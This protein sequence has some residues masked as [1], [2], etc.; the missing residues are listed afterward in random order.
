MNHDSI[1]RRSAALLALTT[2]L[3]VA[4]V[5]CGGPPMTATDGGVR[6]TGADT[7][8]PVM[9]T[10]RPVA[11]ETSAPM[12][13]VAG[14]PLAVDCLLQDQDGESF[15]APAGFMPQRAF[16]P[17]STVMNRDG[18]NIPTRA[19]D[20]EVACSAPSLRLV[21]ATPARVTVLPG[22]AARVVAR[23]EQTSVT[24]GAMVAVTCEAYDQFN[25]PVPM[26]GGEVNVAPTNSGNTVE[27]RTVTFT[28][29]GVYDV[30]C[31]LPGATAEPVRLEVLPGEPADLQISRVPDQPVYARDQLIEVRTRVT[32]R[33]GNEIPDAEVSVTS[34]PEGMT[35]GRGRFRFATD[36]TYR[37]TAQVGSGACTGETAP[38]CKTTT[39][40]VD[41]EGPGIICGPNAN[42]SGGWDATAINGRAGA[43]LTLPARVSDSSGVRAVEVNG[44]AVT[45]DDGTFDVTLTPRE[46]VNFVDITATDESGRENTRSCSFLYGTRWL[47]ETSHM[48]DAVALQLRQA[49][50]DDGDPIN[51]ITSLD[52]VVQ[53]VLNSQG[54][55]DT[56]H[57][58]LLAANPLKV[59]SCDASVFGV[60]VF[61][62]EV[63]YLE[64][65]IN[66]VRTSSLTLVDGGIRIALSIP[67]VRVRLQVRGTIDTTGWANFDNVTASAILDMS[68]SAARRPQLRVRAGSVTS[69]IG[70]ISADFPGI[71]GVI[72][73]VI[74][75]L[76]QNR[77]RDIVNQQIQ[78]YLS[79]D[80]NGILDS[81]VSGLNISTLGS[82]FN[83][84]RIEGT[85]TVRLDF[86]VDFTTV[87]ANTA[88]LLAGIGTRFTTPTVTRMESTPG[89]WQVGGSTYLL[90]PSNT[91]PAA[92]TV[93]T[94]VLNQA[95]NALWRGG[96]FDARIGGGSLGSGVTAVVRTALPPVT[97]P[98]TGGAI[99]LE[100]AALDVELTV[101]NVFDPPLRVRLG[102]IASTR[103]TLTGNTLDFAPV[104]INELH[105]S[106][107]CDAGM[108]QSLTAANRMQLEMFLR[109]VL[110]QIA[111]TSLSSALPA[112]PIPS[113]P[114]PSSL[115]T[116]GLPAGGALGVVSP[117]L[118]L[119]GQHYVLRSR[120]G[121]R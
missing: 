32:D 66:G 100:L 18:M 46:G 65:Q 38:L 47:G 89:V 45:L 94:G 8:A 84:P 28:R 6:D 22:P 34:A 68:L 56:L 11:I 77:L 109:R 114:I 23:V 113:F 31:A 117:T 95:L 90:D 20:L 1:A 74:A 110:Q 63:R 93:H 80:L 50:I 78:R 119:E 102:A 75:S 21:D 51:P 69:N 49:A 37:V 62:S 82:S 111:D 71:T 112:I 13:V 42:G 54:L 53:T 5:G 67:Q 98:R 72:V 81:L 9:F 97:Q 107:P 60:C 36:G 103:V 86:G 105:F 7:A 15:T 92:V 116:F 3:F 106:L 101:P 120:F 55:R 104:T 115:T 108:C 88:R 4:A 26:P 17:A 70:R 43:R 85:G 99:G 16:V 118:S 83:V 41:S 35:F 76:L 59:S 61:R 87:N 25:N 52:D 27:M 40:V 12:T 30:S 24:A 14:T 29:A 58:A 57:T 79:G 73:D 64:N 121:I 2:A 91:Q 19:G 48:A 33:Y 44:A 96:W 10:L 39:I